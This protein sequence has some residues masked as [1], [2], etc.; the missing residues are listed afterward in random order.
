MTKTRDLANLI[1]DSKVGPTEIDTS[2]T[3]TLGGIA[4]TGDL[5]LDV[6]GD[7]ILDADDAQVIFKDAGT[8]IG[9]FNN[10][11]SN[12]NI[13]AHVQDKDITF[14]GDDNGL[15]ITA[16]TLDMSA[17]G[18]AIF[19]DLIKTGNLSIGSQEIDV[20]SGDLTLDV[21]GDIIL[22][23]DGADIKFADGGSTFMEVK[24]ESGSIDFLLN[25]TNDDF[26]FKGSDGGSTITALTLDMSEA[27]A[28]TFNSGATFGGN[29]LVGKTT[30]ATGTAGVALRSNGEVRGTVSGAEAARF[31]RL[32]S[33]GSIV[34]FEKDGASVG[35]INVVA[36]EITIGSNDA[37]LWTSGN[38]NAFLPASTTTGG[39]SN[40]LLDLGSTG[41]RFKDLHLSG[42]ANSYRMKVSTA[43]SGASADASADE[44]VVE[45]NGN[46][47]ISILSGQSNSGSI[48]FGDAGVNWDGY[49]AYSQAN[50]KM[51]LGTAAGAGAVNI[52]SSGNVGVGLTPDTFSS[53]YSALQINGYAYNIGHSGG[54]HYLTNNA[55]YNSGW[56][57]GQTS[58]AQKIEMASGKITLSTAASGS[59]DAAITWI[60]GLKV[61]ADGK[62]GI[63][64]T[65]PQDLLHLNTNNAASHIRV[66]RYESDETL[67][68]GDEIGGIE[69]WANDASSFSGASTVRAA[70]RGEI[71]NTSL[72]TRLEFWTGNSNTAIEERMRIIADGAIGINGHPTDLFY[73]TGRATSTA[74]GIKIGTNG[75]NGIE[76]DNATGSLVGRITI[77]SGST[78]YVTSSDYRLK[79][80]VTDMTSAT[81]RLKQLKPKRF[82]WIADDTNTLID[83][84]LAHEVSSIVPE[85]VAGEKDA[86]H[87]EGHHEAGEIDPQGLDY[88]KLVPLLVKTIQEQQEVIESL[89]ARITALEA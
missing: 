84:F 38:N 7:I 57:Y 67:V 71:Q 86:V 65:S 70:I 75:Y 26:K 49:I 39:A 68:D 82:N 2:G 53:G 89:T 32:S 78:A 44:L 37:F 69:F 47:G 4:A 77:N 83:G 62:V 36:S 50:R 3:Y 15:T 74:M 60:N 88:S 55:Y 5:T 46:A 58:T 64:A 45:S 79:E 25:A 34:G 20:S 22:D 31:S 80:N 81:A 29:L 56:K 18:N 76:F 66:Q 41:R 13:F 33:D 23:A 61:A 8:T 73:V 9:G 48:Y 63:G 14:T 21:A 12:L 16:L 11:S 72:G 6:A 42:T 54:D 51:T 1:A 27:G 19:N 30:I 87:P 59:A 43:S 40:G 28:A 24:H 17:G 52:D 35:S 10:S 85:A